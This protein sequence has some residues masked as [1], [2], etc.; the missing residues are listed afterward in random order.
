MVFLLFGMMIGALIVS[1]VLAWRMV[2]SVH[3]QRDLPERAWQY[4]TVH[5]AYQMRT[6]RRR[7]TCLGLSVQEVAEEDMDTVA[8]YCVQLPPHI[9]FRAGARFCARRRGPLNLQAIEVSTAFP[10]G[11]IRAIRPVQ[12]PGSLLVWPARGQLQQQLLFRG[13]AEISSAP[14]SRVTGGQD[15]FFGLREYRPGDNP[16][17]IHWRRSAT[18]PAPVIREMAQPLPDVL[19]ILLDSRLRDLSEIVYETRERFLRFAATLIDHA[20]T[21][22][23]RVGLALAYNDG[24][25]VMPPA[26]GRGQ[27]CML[28]DA[29]AHMDINTTTGLEETIQH[30]HRGQLR[31][32]QVIV[33]TPGESKLGIAELGLI[34]TACRNLT[35][36]TEAQ[37]EKV[38]VDDRLAMAGR[39]HAA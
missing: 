6:I 2:R 36:I 35:V 26:E 20:F 14:P 39:I 1:A 15:E 32:G 3:L 13:A 27:R 18:K 16:R 11:L 9:V 38:F 25:R 12:A 29:L 33:L 31:Q 23:Y 21:R 5:L 24:V 37:L 22:S 19:W 8:G 7:S 4:Q 17:W 34:R 10:F 28:L 30:L